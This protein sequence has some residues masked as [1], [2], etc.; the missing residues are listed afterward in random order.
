M[1]I[2]FDAKKAAHDT[3]CLNQ[4][5]AIQKTIASNIASLGAA[6]TLEL[7]RELVNEGNDEHDSYQALVG[8]N[9]YS[10]RCG[11][12]LSE[13][14][15]EAIVAQVTEQMETNEGDFKL[16]HMG[17]INELVLEETGSLFGKLPDED[18]ALLRSIRE[19]YI[20]VQY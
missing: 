11:P 9:S 10:V 4:I 20:E 13:D 6:A 17:E 14:G 2:E 8:G 16:F 15:T 5:N 7:L 3:A 12:N 18:V 19:D 1:T